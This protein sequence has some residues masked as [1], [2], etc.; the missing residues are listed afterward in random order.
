MILTFLLS[1]LCAVL[2][3][4]APRGP[5]ISAQKAAMRKLDFLTGK[6]EGDAVVRTPAGERKIRQSE[7]VE[8]RLDGLILLIEGTGRDPATGEIVFNALAT[9]SYD[10]TAKTYRIRAYNAGRY[11]DTELTLEPNGF[12]WGFTAG[13]AKIRNVMTLGPAGE[14][15]EFSE[16]TLAGRPPMRTVEF[17]VLKN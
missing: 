13:P 12:Q 2:S 9:I 4:Q 17:K 5:D 15:I 10:D 11:L 8:Y 7:A 6:W 14:W 1:A 16:V 3:G